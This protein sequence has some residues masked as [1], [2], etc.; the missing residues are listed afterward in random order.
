MN[1][2][3]KTTERVRDARAASQRPDDGTAFLPDPTDGGRHTVAQ[4]A[5]GES[6]GEEYI[7]SA[8]AGEPVDM[9]AQDEVVE[10]EWGGPFLE[11][12]SE[13]EDSSAAIPEPP[14]LHK[15]PPRLQ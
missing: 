1:S 12:D 3:P 2:N 13:G 14:G 15:L 8:T 6:F 11:L 4:M 7:A 5:D 10:E 9:D